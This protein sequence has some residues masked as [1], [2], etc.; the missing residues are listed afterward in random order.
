LC[1]FDIS[2]GDRP[3]ALAENV[4][5]DEEI[6]RAAI[7]NSIQGAAAVASQLAQAAFDL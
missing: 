6:P 2:P 7:E 3:G 5:Q 1:Q 4:E